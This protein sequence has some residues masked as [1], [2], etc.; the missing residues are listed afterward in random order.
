MLRAKTFGKRCYGMMWQL[1]L[2]KRNET[3]A[4]GHS[5]SDGTIAR[6]YPEK[7]TMVFYFTQS[8]EG[9]EPGYFGKFLSLMETNLHLNGN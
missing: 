5:G 2:D 1:V 9:S 3:V 4:F 7:D 6:A 8:K